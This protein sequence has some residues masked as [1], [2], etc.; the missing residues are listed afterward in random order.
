MLLYWTPVAN[1]TGY[2]VSRTIRGA[3]SP[4]IVHLYTDP[5]LVDAVQGYDAPFVAQHPGLLSGVDPS[6]QRGVAY[7]YWVEALLPGSAAATLIGGSRVTAPS[8]V[9]TV[10]AGSPN[11]VIEN[12]QASVAG[13]RTM[14]MR[15]MLSSKGAI[16]GSDVTWT[17]KPFIWGFSYEVSYELVGG[18][19]GLG[20]VFERWT[21]PTSGYYPTFA[22]VRRGVPQGVSVEFC[23]SLIADPDP[24]KP[25]PNATCLT[26]QVP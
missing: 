16:P 11:G 2:Q 6:V 23:V 7:T 4:V 17:W 9:S 26:T 21:V 25:L 10:N 14:V 20:P 24:A 15:G 1:A 19:P 18:M 22:P 8:P 5:K 3:S 12:L 13:T